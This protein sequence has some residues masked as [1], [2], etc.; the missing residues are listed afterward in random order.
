MEKIYEEAV[1]PEFYSIVRRCNTFTGTETSFS[2]SFV[3]ALSKAGFFLGTDR[4]TKCF[5]SGC[6]IINWHETDDPMQAHYS[7]FPHCIYAVFLHY[8]PEDLIEIEDCLAVQV[9]LQMGYSLSSVEAAY[10]QVTGD[11]RQ[12]PTSQKLLDVIFQSGQCKMSDSYEAIYRPPAKMESA[13]DFPLVDISQHKKLKEE[14]QTLRQKLNELEAKQLCLNCKKN[15]RNSTILPCGH[16][17]ICRECANKLPRCLH[18]NALI[19]GIV[20]VYTE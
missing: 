19:R 4:R 1:Y 6:C 17:I 20:N 13:P 14:C 3:N 15:P 11:D 18:C 8:F 2:K 7:Y 9:L 12:E 5:V 16:L 10:K